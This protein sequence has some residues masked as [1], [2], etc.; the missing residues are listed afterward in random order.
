MVCA[1]KINLLTRVANITEPF[2]IINTLGRY[3]YWVPGYLS[4][5]VGGYRYLGTYGNFRTF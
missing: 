4:G 3:R 2:L 5:T 1:N